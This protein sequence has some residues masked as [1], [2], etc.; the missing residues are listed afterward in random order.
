MLVTCNCT[1]HVLVE[2]AR[3]IVVVDCIQSTTSIEL[4]RNRVV[5]KV[6][7]M[8][9]ASIQFGHRKMADLTYL[10]FYFVVRIKVLISLERGYK[11]NISF[12][13]NFLIQLI[14]KKL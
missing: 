10:I 11:S 1:G 9:K 3:D 12:I 14:I 4:E 6:S 5:N 13:F 8:R 7:D 2:V